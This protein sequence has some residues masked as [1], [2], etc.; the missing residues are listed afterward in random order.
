MIVVTRLNGKRF[1][2]NADLVARLEANPDTTITLI[3]GSRYIVAEPMHYVI[4]LIEDYKARVLVRARSVPERPD[5]P[6]LEVVASLDSAP[7]P[8]MQGGTQQVTPFPRTR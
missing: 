7:T 5:R 1:S 8:D 4:E 3:D 2:V 6:A